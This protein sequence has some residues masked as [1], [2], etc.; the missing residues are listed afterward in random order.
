MNFFTSSNT[1]MP[2]DYKGWHNSKDERER[3]ISVCPSSK[4][5]TTI[6]TLEVSVDNLNRPSMFEDHLDVQ[7]SME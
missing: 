6:K 4:P 5:S 1:N 3:I 2:P 7:H